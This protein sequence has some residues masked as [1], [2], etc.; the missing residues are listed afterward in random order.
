[1]LG[2]GDHCKAFQGLA[3]VT[4][5]P[6]YDHQHLGERL[7]EI[8]PD[9]GLLL[10]IVPETFSYTLTEL[11]HYQIPPL[12]TSIGSFAERIKHGQT[13]YLVPPDASALVNTLRAIH[14]DRSGLNT[15][16]KHLGELRQPSRSEMVAA[17]DAVLPISTCK[18]PLVARARLALPSPAGA[19]GQ[20]FYVDHQVPFRRVLAAFLGYAEDKAR[21]TDRLPAWAGRM[22]ARVIRMARRALRAV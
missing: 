5:T 20:P 3:S 10:S 1:L 21:Y 17:Y 6:H 9:L 22:M 19:S 18:Q 15:V 12:A 11:W 4:C 13:G 2:C 7:A 14:A 16:R 8:A